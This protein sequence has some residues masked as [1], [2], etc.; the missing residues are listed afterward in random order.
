MQRVKKILI[1]DD[2]EVFGRMIKLNLEATGQYQ[3]EVETKG[4]GALNA[5]RRFR[6]DLV[7]MDIIMPDLE[8][9]AAATS[10]RSDSAFLETP[11]VFLTA[12]ITASEAKG[13]AGTI[14]GQKFLAKPVKLQTLLQCLDENL[15][16]QAA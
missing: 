6:P 2:E 9:S 10:I 11:I 14:G 16:G 5:C 3:V 13:M 4:E 1:V 7:L 12:A 8:G 15:A